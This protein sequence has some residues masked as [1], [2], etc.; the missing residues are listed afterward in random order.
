M[1]LIQSSFST[2][3]LTP[4]EQLNGQLLSETQKA[5][6]CNWRTQLAQVQIMSR[7][8]TTD[9]YR[10]VQDEAYR[11]GQIDFITALLETTEATVE[12][13]REGQQDHK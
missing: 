2:Y 5:V 11:R 9:I 6:L 4:D 1:Q 3:A 7:I 12:D 13:M 8:D 10:S